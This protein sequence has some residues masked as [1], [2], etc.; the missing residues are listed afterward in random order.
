MSI[1]LQRGQ[2]AGPN[3]LTLFVQNAGTPVDPFSVTYSIYDT[4]GTV[5][6]LF[7]APNLIPT[8]VDV[9]SFYVPFVVPLSANVGDWVVKWYVQETNATPIIEQFLRFGVVAEKFASSLN[10]SQAELDLLGLIRV[11]LRDNNPDRNYHFAPPAGERT[12]NS[13]TTRFGYLWDDKELMD[14]MRIAVMSAN[15][16]PPTNFFPAILALYPLNGP[17]T[18]IPVIGGAASAL[19]AMAIN[20]IAE[21]FGYSIGGI[22]LDL[23]KAQLYMS[24]KE[25]LEGQFKETLEDFLKGGG[26]AIIRGLSQPAYNVGFTTALGPSMREG[27]ISARAF[28]DRRRR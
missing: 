24:M 17:F 7:G 16:K 12:I 14:H 26:A 28:V 22:S 11:V 18:F 21:E 1:S 3:D 20:W 23:S 6:V 2:S 15:M 25:N 27:T 5:P 4:S 8:R 19:R 13:F 9:G 10:L